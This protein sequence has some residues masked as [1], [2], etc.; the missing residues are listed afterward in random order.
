[1]TRRKW[2][3]TS[4]LQNK[5]L[6]MS[7]GI[8]FSWKGI[9]MIREII[10]DETFLQQKSVPAG[11]NDLRIVQDLKDTLLAH[12]EH[13]VGMA[14]NMI[15]FHKNIIIISLGVFNL[16]MINPKINKKFKPYEAEEGCLSLVGTRKIKR[17][18]SIEVTYLDE[19][20][21]QQ[22]QTFSDFPAQIIQHEL[23]HCQ[24]III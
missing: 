11:P 23:D 9:I 5:Y 14:A 17:Y 1:M 8:L 12:K 19:H 22:R 13:C 20:F 6:G 15:G 4:C 2:L 7:C 3:T 16:I 18:H 21:K 10:K 24:G